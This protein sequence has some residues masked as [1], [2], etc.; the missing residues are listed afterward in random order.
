MVGFCAGRLPVLIAAGA[1]GLIVGIVA[2][3][4]VIT[5]NKEGANIRA[6]RLT[7][8]PTVD[9][10]RL[11]FKVEFTKVFSSSLEKSK[12]REIVFIAWMSCY[13]NRKTSFPFFSS[14]S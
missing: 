11:F 3:A 14:E 5:P 4:E 13:E 10:L 2:P 8:R 1:V 6:R 12:I 7:D 9:S